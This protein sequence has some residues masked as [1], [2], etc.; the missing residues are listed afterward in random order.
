MTEKLLTESGLQK[1]LR[2]PIEGWPGYAID[3]AGQV[4]TCKKMKRTAGRRGGCHAILTDNWK[5]K[6][7][8]T[9]WGYKTVVLQNREKQKGFRVHRLVASA[10]LP[11]PENKPYV[12]HINDI[13]DDNRVENL[14]WGTALENEADK[15]RHGN[16]L[17]GEKTPMANL[18][19]TQVIFLKRALLLGVSPTKL[20]N[21]LDWPRRSIYNIKYGTA[22]GWLLCGW[23]KYF[24]GKCYGEIQ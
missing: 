4:W 12:C 10:F 7:G 17:R 23:E 19:Q 8:S 11:N 21:R 5:K 15:L 13:K 6:I 22:W 9:T 3:N 18:N 24:N 1:F 20:A 2:K 14:Y 16:R